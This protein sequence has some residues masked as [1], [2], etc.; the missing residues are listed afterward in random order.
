LGPVELLEPLLV[1]TV[2]MA[3]IRISSMFAL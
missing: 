1:E 3:A 2:A